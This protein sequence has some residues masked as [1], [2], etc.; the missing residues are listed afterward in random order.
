MGWLRLAL[1][2]TF[3]HRLK[4]L[5]LLACIFLTAF[6][7]IAIEILLNSF[8]HEIVARAQSTPLVVGPKGSRFDL[9]L[10]SLYFRVA[11]AEES[12]VATMPLSAVD[13]VGQTQW[14][15][16]I[17]V[18]SKVTSKGF[19]VVGTNARYFSFRGLKV[20]RGDGLVQ[21]G[22]CVLGAG[23]AKELGLEPGDRLLTDMKNVIS[24]AAYPLNMY[25][26][27]VLEPSGSP[28]DFAVF[29]DLKTA[30]II[31]GIGHGHQNVEEV[32]EDKLLSKRDDKIVASAAVLPYTEIT[33]DNIASFHFH[34]ETS[35]FPI[36]ALIAVPRD[37]KTQTLL[38]GRYR[39][40]PSDRQLVQPSKVIGE[41]MNLVFRVKRFFDANAVLIAIS[42]MLLLS[43]IV[44]LSLKLRESEMNTMFKI[45][46]GQGMIFK[47]QL[48]ELGIIFFA[49]AVLVACA[50]WGL[51]QFAGEIVRSML[52]GV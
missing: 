51:Q 27:G 8:E 10:R 16:A 19:P 2:Y 41:L 14:A 34:G 49:A 20:Q 47:L 23:V 38:I 52:L 25:V 7:P 6:L 45:G 35:D 31:D 22:D 46:A 26:R 3:Y 9:T 11:N 44:M 40:A 43:L 1:K 4:S 15:D 36:S 33:P 32:D 37:Q 29:V 48:A 21:I 24:I 50:V 5:L 39:N 17:P 28:D 30:W 13:S 12:D 18:Y 42:T